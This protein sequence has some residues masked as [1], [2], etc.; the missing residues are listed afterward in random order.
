MRFT[1]ILEK[2]HENKSFKGL[3]LTLMVELLYA[4]GVKSQ[5]WSVLN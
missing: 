4:T 5:K 2:S 1:K 3:R